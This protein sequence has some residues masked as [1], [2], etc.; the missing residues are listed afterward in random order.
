[1][2]D[3]IVKSKNGIHARPASVIADLSSKYTGV[4]TFHKAGKVYNGKSIMS[5]MS[6]GLRENET[7][8][9]DV[10][11]EDSSSLEQKLVEIINSI[12]E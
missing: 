9:I 3:V 5:I 1:M 2:T 4:V 8:T 7:V 11:G 6:M 10:V 12:T